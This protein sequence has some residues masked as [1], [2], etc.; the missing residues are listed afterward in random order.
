MFTYLKVLAGTP[1]IRN[2]GRKPSLSSDL[3]TAIYLVWHCLTDILAWTVHL[4]G[5]GSFLLHNHDPY[6]TLFLHLLHHLDHHIQL[7]LPH[8][9][10]ILDSYPAEFSRE[11][12]LM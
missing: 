9:S 4:T 1:D 6:C 5:R 3:N 11:K 2:I 8:Q 10:L 7:P 12:V